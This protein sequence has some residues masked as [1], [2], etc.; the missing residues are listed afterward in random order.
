MTE[1]VVDGTR[2]VP[3]TQ[4]ECKTCGGVGTVWIGKGTKV[5]RDLRILSGPA[6]PRA[7]PRGSYVP[8]P[9]CRRVTE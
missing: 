4:A 3:G 5:E 7:I 6:S 9:V 2:Y 1:V 8:C